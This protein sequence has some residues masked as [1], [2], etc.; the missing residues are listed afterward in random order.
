[1]TQRIGKTHQEM[2]M[3]LLYQEDSKLSSAL[4]ISA[5]YPANGFLRERGSPPKLYAR[6]RTSAAV[7]IKRIRDFENAETQ[8]ET[9][10]MEPRFTVH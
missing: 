1:M 7:M 6:A 2:R 10:R 8:T 4:L 9:E 5:T 3:R